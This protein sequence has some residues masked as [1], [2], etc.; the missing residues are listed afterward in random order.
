MRF[1]CLPAI[2][3]GVLIACAQPTLAEP[4]SIDFGALRGVPG[5]DFSGASTR[6]AP[7]G[8]IW[9]IPTTNGNV[10][11]FDGLFDINFDRTD[12]HLRSDRP[13]E[14]IENPSI[15]GDDDLVSLI[16]DGIAI[17][18]ATRRTQEGVSTGPV[19]L[20]LEHIDNGFYEIITYTAPFVDLEAVM[21]VT[22]NGESLTAGG[23]FPSIFFV[24]EVTHTR[25]RIEITDNLLTMEYE[26]VSGFG[27]VNGFQIIPVVP[28]PATLMAFGLLVAVR[29][30]RR[31]P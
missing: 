4:F 30:N 17:G 10:I 9:L 28:A 7:Q 16:A 18:N 1:H 24:E 6:Y 29:G 2:G 21:E 26:T 5:R 27:V 23:A 31:Q 22:I 12:V 14:A 11:D 13:L 8:G 3:V 20:T 25:H 15:F 19:T